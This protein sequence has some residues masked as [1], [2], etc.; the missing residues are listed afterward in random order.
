MAEPTMMVGAPPPSPRGRTR[1]AWRSRNETFLDW[2]FLPLL[3]QFVVVDFLL[4]PA[5]PVFLVHEG[6]FTGA[7]NSIFPITWTCGLGLFLFGLWTFR[8]KCRLDW[9]RVS[10]YALGLTFAATSLFEIIYQ[11]VGAGLGVGN[12][13]LESQAI[14]L[15]AILF[16]FSSVKYWRPAWYA[17]VWAVVLAMLWWV[18]LAIGYP[19]I[20]DE[21]LSAAEHAYALNAVLKSG[22]FLL[23]ALLIAPHWWIRGTPDPGTGPEASSTSPVTKPEL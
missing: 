23:F 21:G 16:G 7:S 22:T 17:G 3:I 9:V 10:V 4:Y 14:N 20:Y 15:S 11:N 2:I 1:P 6:S 13:Q 19:Q 5:Y 12:Q 18:W 8:R